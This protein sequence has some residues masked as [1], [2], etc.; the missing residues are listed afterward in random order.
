MKN[1]VHHIWLIFQQLTMQQKQA[2]FMRIASF[3]GV[4]GLLMRMHILKEKDSTASMHLNI[5][6]NDWG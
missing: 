2:D 1:P 5:K 3:P 4:V 6:L